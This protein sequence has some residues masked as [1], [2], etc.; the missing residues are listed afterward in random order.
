M[1]LLE[2]ARLIF[3]LIAVIGLIGLAAFA[4]KRMGLAGANGFQRARRLQLVETLAFDQR[5]RAA[6][7]RCDGREHLIVLDNA[8]VTVID[9]DIPAPVLAAPAEAAAI[10]PVSAILDRFAPRPIDGA[11]KLRAVG[12]L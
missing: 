8:S 4:A 5:R 6:I 2:I 10:A 3:A 1:T 9:A 12:G 11:V 7:L